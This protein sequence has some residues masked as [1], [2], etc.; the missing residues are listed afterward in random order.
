MR[1]GWRA[2]VAATTVAI[3]VTGLT[4][5]GDDEGGSAGS[6]DEPVVVEIAFEGDEVTPVGERVEVV[7]TSRST[8]W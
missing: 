5:C 8:W 4:G 6:S 2:V 3:S 1:S 7:W